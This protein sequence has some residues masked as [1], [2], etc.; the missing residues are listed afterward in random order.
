MPESNELKTIRE[1]L[2]THGLSEADAPADPMSLFNTW[3]AYAEKLKFHNANA[4]TLGT[5]NERSEP[6][7]RNVLLR[8]H[9]DGSFAFYT[10]YGSRKGRDLAQKETAAA[11]LGW[12]ELERQ[13][14]LTGT[15]E[16]MNPES[17]DR[18]FSGR[19]R[20]SRIS[21]VVSNQSHPVRDRRELEDKW[22]QLDAD[23]G[24]A[25]PERPAHW[26]G[27]VLIADSVEF[28]QGRP[29]RLHDRLFYTRTGK[30]WSLE[31]LAP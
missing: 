19:D 23:L 17:S 14:R 20:G 9:A 24:G 5:V 25:S 13:I 1:N 10:N 6:S 12:L 7:L 4:M 22:K 18:Y 26:G 2:M 11:L 3:M 21:A 27:Y 31:R 15:V 28:W 30:T 29:H 16:K 8:G